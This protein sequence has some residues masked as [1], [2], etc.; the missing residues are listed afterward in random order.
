MAK[1]NRSSRSKA[2]ED[3][4]DLAPMAEPAVG[5]L[6][7][8]ASEGASEPSMPEAA[9]EIPGTSSDTAQV[10]VAQSATREKACC[11]ED[12]PSEADDANSDDTLKL[13]DEASSED[14]PEEDSQ[15]S[16]PEGA[17]KS[18]DHDSQ[19]VDEEGGSP[20]ATP[21]VEELQEQE[22]KRPGEEVENNDEVSPAKKV[23]SEVNAEA[24]SGKTVGCEE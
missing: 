11:T 2:V 15:T 16:I 24:S 22:R 3:P 8:A 20:E 18:L 1:K 7:D 14:Q 12:E 10:A 23:M 6:P 21:R 4:Q 9:R 5:D 13:Q 19:E 17:E